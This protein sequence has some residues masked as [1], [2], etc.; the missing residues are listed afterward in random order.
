MTPADLGFGVNWNFGTGANITYSGSTEWRLLPYVSA[1]VP[2]L[3]PG[4]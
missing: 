2:D 3:I 1:N 4:I